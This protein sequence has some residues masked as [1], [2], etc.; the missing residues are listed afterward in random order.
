M[1]VADSFMR[2]EKAS[3]L[4][5]EGREL[6]NPSP[7]A[8]FPTKFH[9]FSEVLSKGRHCI[10]SFLLFHFLPQHLLL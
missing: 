2:D 7:A 6:I 3:I 1:R 10:Y 8:I 9:T 5:W 4:V